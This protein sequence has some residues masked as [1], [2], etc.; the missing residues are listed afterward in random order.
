[1]D[2]PGQRQ[3]NIH[4]DPEHLGGVY[5]NFANI[6]FSNYEFTVT[7]AR[8]DHE[9]GEGEI[10]GVVVS[11]VNMSPRFMREL[12]TRWRTPGRS[13]RPARASATSPRVARR[14]AGRALRAAVIS[15]VHANGAALAAVLAAIDEEGVDELWCLGDI[16]RL[17]ARA[18]TRLPAV[19]AARADVALVGNHDLV[20]LGTAAASRCEFN[21]DAAAAARWT[22][23]ALEDDRGRSCR[24]RRPRR[25]ATA[26]TSSTRSAADPV[27]DYVLSLRTRRRSLEATDAPLVLVGH[28]HVP[29]AVTGDEQAHGGHARRRHEVDLGPGRWLLNP[30]SVGQPRD[31]DPAPPTSLL[32]LAAGRATVQA[33]PYEVGADAGGEI[34]ARPGWRSR[35][36]S[37]TGRSG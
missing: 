5:A 3:L 22:Q 12:L 29:S 36:G 27:W 25:I 6:T 33:R 24:A 31:A 20:A 34:A 19:V 15:D 28:T 9:V 1:M 23:A 26:S 7:F 16:G 32:D 10:P 14:R 17:R 13:G 35:S 2:D 30:G 8:I 18:R 21:P 37:S 11:R 4:M